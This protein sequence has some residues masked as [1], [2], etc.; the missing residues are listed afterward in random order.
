MGDGTL[1]S[2]RETELND[3]FPAAATEDNSVPHGDNSVPSE[4][5][6]GPHGGQLCPLG[7][8]SCHVA[9]V[10]TRWVSATH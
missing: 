10:Q 6:S 9:R 4:D 7:G 2:R 5:N 1:D 8:Q 3:T